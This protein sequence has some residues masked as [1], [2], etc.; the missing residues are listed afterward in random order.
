MTGVQTCALPISYFSPGS[1]FRCEFPTSNYSTKTLNGRDTCEP[2][3]FFSSHPGMSTNLNPVRVDANL[4]CTLGSNGQ[5]PS[6]SLF[7][8]PLTTGPRP[9]CLRYGNVVRVPSL[10]VDALS[11]TTHCSGSSV[12]KLTID[13]SAIGRITLGVGALIFLPSVKAAA[14][15]CVGGWDWVR[16]YLFLVFCGLRT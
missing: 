5:R 1:F 15:Q 13:R 16:S 10:Q 12:M 14:A 4:S 7:L 3:Y 11:S 8:S 6:L 9:V 2:D